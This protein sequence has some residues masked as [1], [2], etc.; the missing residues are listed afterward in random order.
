[1]AL[2]CKAVDQGM[3]Q[4]GNLQAKA[5]YLPGHK[6]AVDHGAQARVLGRL[7]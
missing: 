1:M 6:S 7:E 3:R 5:F 4:R 2:A